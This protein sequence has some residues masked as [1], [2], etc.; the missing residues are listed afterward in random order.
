[1]Y[2]AGFSDFIILLASSFGLLRKTDINKLNMEPAST[3][4]KRTQKTRAN[5]LAL[6]PSDGSATEVVATFTLV[7]DLAKKIEAVGES[8]LKLQGKFFRAAQRKL[9]S[10]G[11][12][13]KK[14][15][16]IVCEDSEEEV[17]EQKSGSDNADGAENGDV[18]G[19]GNE[20][21]YSKKKRTKEDID[22]DAANM[23]DYYAA[24]GLSHLTFEASANSI[25]KAYKKAALKYH[26]DKLG[27][28]FTEKDKK[29]WL[30][31]QKAYDN[32]SDPAKR[33]KYDSSLPFD[34]A[35]PARSDIT[36]A[37][38]YEKFVSVFNNNARFSVKK[39]V[40]SL[41]DNKTSMDDV[42]KFYS[43]WNNFKTWREFSQY[44]EY[45]T[46]EANDRYEKRWME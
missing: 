18:D 10:E 2:F 43:F 21:D 19:E 45:D 22:R 9:A 17:E 6:P 8:H 15:K 28:K 4:E 36:D 7:P 20:Q 5:L 12:K 31:V 24:L 23:E 1:M 16:N 29:V 41:G 30:Q 40:P 46:E 14:G 34:E 26:P 33:K 11:V 37:N 25:G 44:D 42:R 32:L 39:P 13:D 38:F 27:D 3:Q 35:I